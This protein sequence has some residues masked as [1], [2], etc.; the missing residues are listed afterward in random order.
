MAIYSH[1]E[2]ISFRKLLK[3]YEYVEYSDDQLIDYLSI[4]W[5]LKTK[6]PI[7]DIKYNHENFPNKLNIDE[8]EYISKNFYPFAWSPVLVDENM[9]L[10]DGQHRFYMAR[11]FV[12]LKYLDV[13]IQF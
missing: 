2:K 5:N 8:V 4:G 12:G 1:K 3:D 7:T 9:N 10:I 13:Y 11:N 6:I